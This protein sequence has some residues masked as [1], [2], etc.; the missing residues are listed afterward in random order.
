MV[1]SPVQISQAYAVPMHGHQQLVSSARNQSSLA[2]TSRETPTHGDMYT[3][4]HSPMHTHGHASAHARF[5]TP[6]YS[7]KGL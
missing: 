5:Q 4:T 1:P 2:N 3:D 6:A 7:Q